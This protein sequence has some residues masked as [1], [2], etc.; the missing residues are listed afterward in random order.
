[1]PPPPNTPLNSDRSCRT[2]MAS[3]RS[4]KTSEGTVGWSESPG[5][6]TKSAPSAPYSRIT[7]VAVEIQYD[8]PQAQK[9]HQV[10]LHK[11]PFPLCRECP[12]L[13]SLTD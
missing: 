12:N 9:P 7:H 4:F 13:A 5:D 8:K 10:K 2:S 1:M 3:F 6:T 11:S